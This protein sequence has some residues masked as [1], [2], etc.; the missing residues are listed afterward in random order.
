[1]KKEIALNKTIL[2]R[3]VQILKFKKK[4]NFFIYKVL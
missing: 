1:M 4:V 3:N 2:S